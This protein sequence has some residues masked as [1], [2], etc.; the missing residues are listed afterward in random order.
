MLVVRS[1][2]ILYVSLNKLYE[3]VLALSFGFHEKCTLQT[4]NH[5]VQTA[6]LSYVSHV[7]CLRCRAKKT[8]L[9]SPNETL[10]FSLTANLAKLS[11]A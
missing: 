2:F 10:L 5:T 4:L 7:M 3:N 1:V 8:F 11:D 6:L 9:Y